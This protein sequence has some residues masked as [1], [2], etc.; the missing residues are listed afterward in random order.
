[1]ESIA[2]ITKRIEKLEYEVRLETIAKRKGL[3][4]KVK[5][6]TFY[7]INCRSSDNRVHNVGIYTLSENAYK[8]IPEFDESLDE[9]IGG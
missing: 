1:M 8:H 7:T 5:Y 4:L 2:S 9:P 3:V 6:N